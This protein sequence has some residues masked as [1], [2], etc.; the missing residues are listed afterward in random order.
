MKDKP[1]ANVTIY[2][3]VPDV[4]FDINKKIKDLQSTLAYKDNF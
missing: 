3:A 2:R 1:H 4:N